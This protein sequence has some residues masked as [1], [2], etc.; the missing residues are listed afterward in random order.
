MML[1]MTNGYE[2]HIQVCDP[3]SRVLL[4][5]KNKEVVCMMF[6]NMTLRPLP[7]LHRKR[8]RERERARARAKAF[9]SGMYSRLRCGGDVDGVR[10]VL[11]I[12]MFR[13]C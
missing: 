9:C 7:Y 2:F 4:F 1:N 12:T 11:S 5:K 6:L 13:T 10:T 3:Y 8:Q